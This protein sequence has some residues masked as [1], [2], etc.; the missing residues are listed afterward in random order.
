MCTR[1][2]ICVSGRVWIHVYVHMSVSLYTCMCEWACMG[3]CGWAYECEYVN[4][5]VYV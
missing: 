4:V 5:Y 3:G 1:V 2:C